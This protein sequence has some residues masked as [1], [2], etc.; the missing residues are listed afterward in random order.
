MSPVLGHVMTLECRLAEFL[1][2]AAD[3]DAER[4]DRILEDKALPVNAVQ[5][6][7]RRVAQGLGKHWPAWGAQPGCSAIHC[8]ADAGAAAAVETLLRR[9]ASAGEMTRHGVSPLQLAAFGGH[10]QVLSRLLAEP[11][12]EVNHLCSDLFGAT[13]PSALHL[14]CCAEDSTAGATCVARLLAAGANVHARCSCTG[15]TPLHYAAANGHARACALLVQ[16]GAWLQLADLG[17]ETPLTLARS[18]RAR[19]P[20]SDL[21]LRE[22][23]WTPAVRLLWLGLQSGPAEAARALDQES[24]SDAELLPLGNRNSSGCLLQGLTRDVVRLIAA[25][26]VRGHA[27]PTDEHRGA[28][29]SAAAETSASGEAEQQLQEDG[30]LSVA[31]LALAVR[32]LHE[33]AVR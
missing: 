28:A 21:V 23:C 3:N 10:S 18:S 11:A 16:A 12:T 9:G 7:P 29:P 20:A 33:S 30:E 4:I 26:I 5:W 22:L 6:T 24:S 17:G 14:A 32:T 15:R 13:G 2:A 1:Q 25:A 31:E 27:P 8:A 19:S